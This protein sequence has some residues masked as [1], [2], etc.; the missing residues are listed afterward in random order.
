MAMSQ[1]HPHRP[2]AEVHSELRLVVDNLCVDRGGRRVLN[3][4]ALSLSGGEALIVTGPNG[5]GKST[6]LRTLVGLLPR[7]SGVVLL[8]GAD[9]GMLAPHAHY[10]AHADGMKAALT[11]Q[12]NLEF[13]ADY[14]SNAESDGRTLSSQQA[15]ERVGLGH[16]A[17]APFGALS[18]GQKRRVALARLLVAF[19]PVWLLDEPL[20]ALDKSSRAR[21]AEVMRDHLALGGMI[22]AATHESLGVEDAH[23]LP[24]KGAA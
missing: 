24:L 10:L 5:V 1:E 20:T 9:E 15:L 22:I 2:H 8:Q 17:R 11:A 7:A 4:L 3:G 23:E 13:W 18:A 19:R 14:L 6:L 21:F 12:E 16:V